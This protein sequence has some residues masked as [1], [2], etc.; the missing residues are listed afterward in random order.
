MLPIN[1]TKSK[2]V[3]VSPPD[4]VLEIYVGT[5]WFSFEVDRSTGLTPN[6]LS[7]R[8][9][10]RSRL[11][12][13]QFD[14]RVQVWVPVNNFSKFNKEDGRAYFPRYFLD[15]FLESLPFNTKYNLTQVQPY[16]ARSTKI[17][18]KKT[19]IPRDM[20]SACAEFILKRKFAPISAIPGAGKTALSIYTISLLSGPALIVLGMLIPQWHKSL[21]QFTTLKNDDICIVQG[22]DS[23]AAIWKMVDKKFMPKVVLFSTRT[24]I[25]YIEREPPYNTIPSF[26]EFQRIL[27]FKVKVMDEVHTN[28]FANTRIDL[29]SN[30]EY[31]IY[32]SATYQRT[33]SIGRKIFDT[34]YPPQMRFGEQF[35]TKYTTVTMVQYNL[36]ISPKHLNK[37]KRINGY[38]HALYE[39]FLLKYKSFYNDFLERVLLPLIHQFF[40]TCRKDGQRLL[41]LC[42]TRDFASKV[43]QDIRIVFTELKVNKYFAG[44]KGKE[45]D[46]KNLESDIIVSTIKSCGTG[47]DIKDLK[48]CI[49]TVSFSSEPLASQVMGRL[50]ELKGEDTFF[51][52]MWNGDIPTHKHHKRSRL[53][54]Y[55]KKALK[56]YDTII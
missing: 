6:G 47:R 14:P 44:G 16:P 28:F 46:L 37:F 56:V 19:F 30:I 24:L 5:T 29:F 38:M 25:L 12:Q 1:L 42:Q 18:M 50:R 27:G 53:E 35:G 21:K 41:I 7:V 17:H 43:Y 55:K 8:G 2:K 48:T 23:L 39:K 26:A 20:Q 3:A 9:F 40:I 4:N 10:V 45:T 49:N 36:S 52:D 33:D 15:S 51:V 54:V 22:F 31:N 11:T 32:L 13:Y 34:I